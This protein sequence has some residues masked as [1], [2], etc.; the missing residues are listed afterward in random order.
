[1]SR[2]D[3]SSSMT[4]TVASAEGRVPPQL[5]LLVMESVKAL[6]RAETS[7]LATR[8]DRSTGFRA[9]KRR[10]RRCC[11]RDSDVGRQGHHERVAPGFGVVDGDAATHAF[12]QLAGQVEADAEA[13]PLPE[14]RGFDLVEGCEHALPVAVGDAAAV[15]AN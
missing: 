5:R 8:A 11:P 2:I 10:L 7:N 9:S 14:Q 6:M 13:A 3:G 4:R 1:M 15:V 12:D